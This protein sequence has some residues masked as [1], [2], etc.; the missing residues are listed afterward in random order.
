MGLSKSFATGGVAA[1]ENL[2]ICHNKDYEIVSL[3][4]SFPKLTDEILEAICKVVE[5]YPEELIGKLK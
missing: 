3:S 5:M 2:F 4:K 1:K